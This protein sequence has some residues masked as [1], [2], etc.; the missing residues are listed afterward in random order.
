MDEFIELSLVPRHIPNI[1]ILC[2]NG[3]RET[4][5]EPGYEATPKLTHCANL[6]GGI[7]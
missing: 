4:G 3:S 1:E 5:N 2:R 7:S 6:A